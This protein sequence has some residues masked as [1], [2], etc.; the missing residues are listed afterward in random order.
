MATTKER[1]RH[2]RYL[3]KQGRFNEVG[4]LAR[5]TL[6]R[7]LRGV[8]PD[9]RDERLRAKQAAIASLLHFYDGGPQPRWP[10]EIFI[11]VSN[12]CDLQ[13][14]MCPTFSA[15]N[16]NRHTNISRRQRGFFDVELIDEK[17]HDA[18]RH[19]LVVHAFGYGE[20]TLHPRFTELVEKL[21]RYDVMV[22]FFTHGMH[23]DDALCA[24]M[25]RQR[26]GM[27]TLSFSGAEADQ[28]ENIYL[29]GDFERVLDNLGR[30]DRHKRRAG[31]RFPLIVINSLAFRHHVERLPDFV[32]VMAEAGANVIHL[33]PLQTF[34]NITELKGHAAIYDESQAEVLAQAHAVAREL[35]VTLATRE[36]EDTANRPAPE[37]ARPEVP[38]ERLKEIAQA[39][40]RQKGAQGEKAEKKVEIQVP[41]PGTVTYTPV[42][43]IHCTEPFKTLYLS[44]E[45]AA[46]PCC[47]KD[48]KSMWGDMG[49]QTAMEIWRSP[50][51]AELR[52]QVQQRRYPLDLCHHCVKTR[53]YPKR[54]PARV[55]I[56]HY[57]QWLEDKY[58][59]R[60]PEALMAKVEALPEENAKL[61]ERFDA[62]P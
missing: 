44:Y 62:A 23:L 46:F 47:F 10:L 29:G 1:L 34:D 17:L 56:A 4:R 55:H 2:L 22:D 9:D 31:A 20:P 16:T 51:M 12:L 27:I 11:E 7:R 21:G 50:L 32:R 5:R 53:A 57:S 42:P 24:E 38:I 59:T 61:F 3:L 25:V 8:D 18:L 6:T 39:R 54:N 58:G 28:Y 33:K 14:A 41:E 15:L 60:L 45:G 49:R 36:Y 30:L 26:V 37:P 13:C 40:R 43:D 48:I 52:T 35:G 19:A